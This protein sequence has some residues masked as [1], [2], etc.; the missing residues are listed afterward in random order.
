MPTTTTAGAEE[1]RKRIIREAA[2]LFNKT[3]YFNT[4]MDDIAE[5]VG[6]RKP[7]L[8]YY[9]SSKEQILY[10]MHEEL[11]DNLISLHQSRLNTRISCGQ[12]LQEVLIDILEEIDEFP[13]YVRAFFEHYRELDGDK[14]KQIESKR[15]AYFRMIVDVIRKGQAQGEFQKSDPT[16]TALAF[17]GMC[18]WT[19]QWYNPQ[20]RWRPREI[21]LRLWDTFMYGVA[22]HARNGNS[23]PRPDA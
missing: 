13:G 4:S 18:N 10:L 6:L 14:K 19:Y 3:G 15:D 12:L 21:A 9:I 2:A 8:Y 22:N 7:T 23:L 17:F 11:I 20:G 1:R 16:F 5:A